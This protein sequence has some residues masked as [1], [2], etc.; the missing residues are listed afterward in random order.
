MIGM[1]KPIKVNHL[2]PNS[3]NR[4]GRKSPS[5]E[6]TP[7]LSIRSIRQKDKAKQL[8]DIFYGIQQNLVPENRKTE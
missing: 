8:T 6:D 3:S 2:N 4:F 1:M 5:L 7:P